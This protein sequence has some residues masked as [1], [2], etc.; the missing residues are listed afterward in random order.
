MLEE[1]SDVSGCVK[2]SYRVSDTG[3]GMSPEFMK[4]LFQP[5]SRQTD[6][7]VNSIQGTGLGLA[8]TKKMVDLM[9]GTIECQSEQGVGTTFTVVIDIP[10]TDRLRDDMTLDPI[11]VL[12][13]DDDEILLRT[14]LDTLESLGVTAE[15]A[16][17]GT[18]ALAMISNRQKEGRNY[19]I[20]I[21]DWKMPDMNGIETVQRI[22]SESD[23]NVPVL[24]MSA[25]DLSD[26][27][28][29]AKKAGADGFV[30]KPLFRSV[31]YVLIRNGLRYPLLCRSFT[32]SA[33]PLKK[34]DMKVL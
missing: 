23:V 29:A 20:V 11:D 32:T 33:Q 25:Y 19:D 9:R 5:F 17:S 3:I 1:E 24:L 6:S 18:E 34:R 30:S 26:V 27:E 8:I 22:R 2:L 28:E 12:I 7:R 14:T 13:V 4:S 31:L 16:Q 15:C 10:V 21:L